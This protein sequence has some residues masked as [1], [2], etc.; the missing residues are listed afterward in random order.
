M[1]LRPGPT[2]RGSF[3]NAILTR[4]RRRTARVGYLVAVLAA[5][6]AAAVVFAVCACKSMR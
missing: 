2:A 5:L 4:M 3:P 6:L 1:R